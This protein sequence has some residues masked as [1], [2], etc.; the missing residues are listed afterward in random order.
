MEKENKP[1]LT[2]IKELIEERKTNAILELS[3]TPFN[4]GKYWEITGEIWALSYVLGICD[5]YLDRVN[6]E[7]LESDLNDNE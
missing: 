6:K 7:L 3:N 4:S 5:L 2:Q 1:I